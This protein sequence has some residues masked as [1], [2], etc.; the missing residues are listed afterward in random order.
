[1]NVDWFLLLHEF[2]QQKDQHRLKHSLIKTTSSPLEMEGRK[3]TF[4]HSKLL[5]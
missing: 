5:S 1:M 4:A 2:Q 3:E